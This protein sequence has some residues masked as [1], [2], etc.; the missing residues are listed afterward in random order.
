M[1]TIFLNKVLP[2][3]IFLLAIASAL[4]TTSIEKAPDNVV[5][6]WVHDNNGKPCNRMVTCSDVPNEFC[7][8]SYPSGQVAELKIGTVCVGPLYR[9]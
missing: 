2:V 5:N 9:P 3:M 7:K 4:G 1:K 6:G 8:V